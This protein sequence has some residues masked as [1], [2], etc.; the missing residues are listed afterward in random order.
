METMAQQTV[1]LSLEATSNDGVQLMSFRVCI[2]QPAYAGPVSKNSNMLPTA[3]SRVFYHEFSYSIETSHKLLSLARQHNST[4]TAVM[5]TLLS[6][7]FVTRS[8]SHAADELAKSKTFQLPFLPVNRRGSVVASTTGG[9][10]LPPA[11]A[12]VPVALDSQMLLK[13]IK[14]MGD[15]TAMKAAIWEVADALGG[16]FVAYKVR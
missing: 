14:T 16:Q 11:L 15:P 2:C 13:I 5:G 12:L 8:G 4:I 1:E 7:A 9:E 3:S 10:Y 6:V